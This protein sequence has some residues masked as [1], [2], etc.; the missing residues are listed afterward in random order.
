MGGGR[1]AQEGLRSPFVRPLRGKRIHRLGFANDICLN[2]NK[3]DKMSL[4]E[5][6]CILEPSIP[7][8]QIQ[9]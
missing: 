4:K 9:Q 6:V 8:K 1:K 7:I 2:T 5:T 3:C